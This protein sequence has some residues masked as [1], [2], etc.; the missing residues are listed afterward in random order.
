VSARELTDVGISN[1]FREPSGEGKPLTQ[2][3]FDAFAKKAMEPQPY[4]PRVW[5]PQQWPKELW[6]PMWG[7]EGAEAAARLLGV[8]PPTPEQVKR[9]EAAMEKYARWL[10]EELDLI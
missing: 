6:V 3:D 2:E 8:D 10:C 1:F 9:G 7:K 4:Q 5:Y